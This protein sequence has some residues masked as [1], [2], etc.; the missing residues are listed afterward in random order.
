MVREEN[1]LRQGLKALRQLHDRL[2]RIDVR[3]SD[4]GWSDLVLALDVRAMLDTA[5]ATVRCA[6]ERRETRGAHNRSDFPDLD[7]NLTVNFYVRRDPHGG[8]MVV[9]SEAVPEVPPPLRPWAY[10]LEEHNTADRLL[11]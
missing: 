1:G 10:Q 9:S 3:P 6:I 8:E 11:E 5:E 4:E 7:P 2:D